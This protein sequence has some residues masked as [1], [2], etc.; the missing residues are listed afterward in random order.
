M[1]RY[2]IA[3]SAAI[4][5]ALPAV[6]ANIILTPRVDAIPGVPLTSPGEFGDALPPPRA[7]L[8]FDCKADFLDSVRGWSEPKKEYCCKRHNA[9]CKGA[10]ERQG[11]QMNTDFDCAE[12][13]A[14]WANEWS[15]G[16]QA[17][18]CTKYGKGCHPQPD[19][20]LLQQ[21][22]QQEEQPLAMPK[23]AHESEDGDCLRDA[24][25]KDHVWSAHKKEYC[26]RAFGVGCTH[27]AV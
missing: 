27:F 25:D 11:V 15:D 3:A 9:F 4:A 7:L 12:G 24:E 17:W 1:A 18:C 2:S 5:A 6:A 26:C 21:A 10:A 8:L 13:W 20:A 14:N 23:V 19:R 22:A 16:K